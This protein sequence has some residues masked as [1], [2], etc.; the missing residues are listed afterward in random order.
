MRTAGA[1]VHD[2]ASDGEKERDRLQTKVEARFAC[3]NDP[4]GTSGETNRPGYDAKCLARRRFPAGG[5]SKLHGALL[6]QRLQPRPFDQGEVSHMLKN[7][8]ERESREAAG[9]K[10]QDLRANKIGKAADRVDRP[11]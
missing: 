9:I 8:H 1:R 2:R 10:A 4:C 5:A 7:I 3:L 6:S 11:S